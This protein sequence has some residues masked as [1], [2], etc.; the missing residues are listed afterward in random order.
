MHHERVSHGL[1]SARFLH[2]VHE[3]AD[4]RAQ[5]VACDG[6]DASALPRQC[7][8]VSLG[9]HCEARPLEKLGLVP[10]Q[11]VEQHVLLLGRRD[12]LDVGQVD[13]HEQSA[14]PLDVAQEL[15]AE[16]PPFGGALDEPRYVGDHDLGVVETDDS[17]VGLQRGERVVGHLG[18]GRRDA[19]DQGAL[20]GV[21]ESD[22]GD[23]GDEPQLHVEPALFARLALL[24]ERRRPPPVGQEAGV[25]AAAP[26]A[27]GRQPGVALVH[28][29]GDDRA[30]LLLDR[31]ALGHRDARVRAVGPVPPAALAVD[32]VRRPTEGMVL[33]AE[34]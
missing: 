7:P 15:M 31:R 33:E 8:D 22:E 5:A 23:V 6:G 21:R 1:G 3:P 32:P 17:E 27:S 14:G 19:R 12:L 11:L 20:P 28:E 34:Q 9:A 4:E 29:I 2:Q 30:V 13:E 24:G 16:T 26:A 10:P 18:L 25:A